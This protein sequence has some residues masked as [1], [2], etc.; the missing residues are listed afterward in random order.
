MLHRQGKN[1]ESATSKRA[2][3]NQ[4]GDHALPQRGFG[5]STPSG[6]ERK[7][8]TPSARDTGGSA[9]AD[10][11]RRTSPK[12]KTHEP[13]GTTSSA[14]E[15]SNMHV[16]CFIWRIA[17]SGPGTV[18]LWLLWDATLPAQALAGSRELPSPPRSSARSGVAAAT[19]GLASVELA[20]NLL[21]AKPWLCIPRPFR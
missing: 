9:R 11:E 5:L 20:R 14:T 3:K 1:Q 19:I 17:V 10:R 8:A 2:K 7:G 21:T 18:C 13:A 15:A 4:I 12:A 16:A 6:A